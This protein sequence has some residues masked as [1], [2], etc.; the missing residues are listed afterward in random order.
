MVKYGNVFRCFLRCGSLR[1]ITH[2]CFNMHTFT[3]WSHVSR[4]WSNKIKWFFLR[5]C[6]HFVYIH[7]AIKRFKK[8][9][10]FQNICVEERESSSLFQASQPEES[11]KKQCGGVYFWLYSIAYWMP[12]QQKLTPPVLLFSVFCWLRIWL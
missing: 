4:Y 8:K 12:I 11:Q 6:D 5:K 2:R 7:Y 3:K 9:F 1:N 10:Y